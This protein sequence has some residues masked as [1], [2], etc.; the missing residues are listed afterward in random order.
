LEHQVTLNANAKTAFE[1]HAHDLGVLIESYHT[2][3]GIYTSAAF[4]Q[5]VGSHY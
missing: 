5:K 1:Q 4:T 2:N 3:N